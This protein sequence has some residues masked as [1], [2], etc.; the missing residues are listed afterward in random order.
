MVA[1]RVRIQE[2]AGWVD[3]FLTLMARKTF[4]INLAVAEFIRILIK[5]REKFYK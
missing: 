4:I 5:N 1:D 2:N 3:K